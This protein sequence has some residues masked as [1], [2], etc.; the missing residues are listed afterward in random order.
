MEHGGDIRRALVTGAGK[1]LGRAIALGLARD[2]WDIAVHYRHSRAEAEAVVGEIAALGRRAVAV[3]C[4]LGDAVQAGRLVAQCN[5]RLGALS[6]LVNNASLF[7]NDTLE[8]LEPG[9][10][11]KHMNVNLRAPLLLARDFAKQLPGGA[12]GCIVNLLD[13]K[14]FN[15]NPD[16]LSYTVAK[17]GLEG[18]TR[19]LAM[20]LAPKVRVCGVAP[21]ITLVSGEQTVAGFEKAHRMA[22]LG[23]SSDVEDVVGAV[24]YV[25]GARALTGTT[26]VVDGGQHLWGMRRDVQFEA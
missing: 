12:T 2:G 11:D 9:H 5:D 4:D 22:P 13:Q 10:W 6:C 17:I 14:V 26:L 21:G 23:R 24:K 8:S 3:A 18:A 19:M 15:L 7:E 1:R 25:V 16:F 20:A